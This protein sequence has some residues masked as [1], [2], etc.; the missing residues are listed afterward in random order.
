MNKPRIHLTDLESSILK[1]LSHK[2]KLS[3]EETAIKQHL[4][5][6]LKE[7]NTHEKNH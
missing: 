5:N 7:V 1:H 4:L 6:K 2:A 3:P